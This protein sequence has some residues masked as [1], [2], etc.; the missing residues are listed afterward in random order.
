MPIIQFAT[1][2][3]DVPA[4]VVPRFI[5]DFQ[6]GT[7]VWTWDTHSGLCIQDTERNG[8]DDSDFYMLVWNP[9]KKCAESIMF[10]TTRGWSYPSYGSKPDATPEV[11]AEYNAWRAEQDRLAFNAQETDRVANP[12]P[13]DMPFG[14]RVRL[15]KSSRKGCKTPYVAGEVGEVLG[16]YWFGTFYVNG[17]QARNRF[18]GRLGLRMAD[19]R[20]VYVAMTVVR[21][22]REPILR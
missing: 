5:K 21:L 16:Q 14:T 20:K 4:G 19:G 17:Y 11:M 8:Y 13:D 9:A 10:A 18:N 6:L 2:A 1:R 15:L 12:D 3:E 22:D 7:D